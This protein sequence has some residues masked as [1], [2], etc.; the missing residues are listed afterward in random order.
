MR[1]QGPYVIACCHYSGWGHLPYVTRR[2]LRLEVSQ[3][4][5]FGEL[6]TVELSCRSPAQF[7]LL[8]VIAD[9]NNRAEDNCNDQI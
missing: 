9:N 7:H 5:A 6:L 4:V 2:N 1:N 3:N 8:Q